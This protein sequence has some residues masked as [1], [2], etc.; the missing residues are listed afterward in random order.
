MRRLATFQEF[1][2]WLEEGGGAR[3]ARLAF[4]FAAAALIS[5]QVADR[6]FHGPLTEST[7]VQ[8]DL[9]RQLA[10]GR[11]FTTQVNYPE[12]AAFL[13]ARGQGFARGTPYPELRH[14]PLYALT[15]AGALRLLPGAWRERLFGPAA[16]PPDGFGAD[17]FVLL[18]NLALFW[19]A[20]ALLHRLARRL[21]EARVA[22]LATLGL[23]LSVSVWQQVVALNGT[24]LLLVL[25]LLVFSCWWEVE[26]RAEAGGPVRRWAFLLGLTGG[27][28]ALGQYTAATLA[29]V[30]LG[31]LAWR[32]PPGRRLPALGCWL[33]GLLLVTLPWVVRNVALTGSP[34]AL[35]ARDLALK[36]GD[37]TAE[38]AVALA[39]WSAE[40]PP[41][42]LPKVGNKLLTYLQD[43]AKG[44]L[45]SGGA[46]WFTAF[47]VAGLLYS[48]RL[49]TVARLRWAFV[50]S[51]LLALAGQAACDSGEVACPVVVW[52]SPLLILFGAGF[53]FVLLGSQAHLGRTPW[54]AGVVLLV[55]QAAPLAHDALEPRRL[56]FQ[57]P[58]YFPGLLQGMKAEW[59]RRGG[60][61]YGVMADIPAGLAWYG[62]LRTWA[63]PARLSDLP[64]ISAQQTQVGLLLTPRTLD[65]PFFSELNAR[66][67]FP[68]LARGAPEAGG[69][70]GEVYAGLLTGNLPADFPLRVRQKLADNLYVLLNPNVVPLPGK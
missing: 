37:P 49:R 69:G 24:A 39:A 31:Y 30:M 18:V 29:P 54:L 20:L 40:G 57:Y 23:L 10:R 14:A 1:V 26:E 55:L 4:F 67:L 45:W 70:W 59:Q 11:G 43:A 7:F 6:Q 65:R 2:H 17:Y 36:A 33:L 9:G 63:Q 22:W 25:A 46:L 66:P 47:F 44:G 61:A 8:L 58:P 38:P 52:F 3:W 35:A 50:A 28:L 13:A 5:W 19:L 62:D 15:I 34:V 32:L 60:T 51:L 41:L 68:T 12:T 42:L 16:P 64:R 48:F 53:F 27:L 56:H 21:F